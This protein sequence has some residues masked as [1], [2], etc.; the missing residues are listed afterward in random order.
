MDGA[1]EAAPEGLARAL[2]DFRAEAMGRM[3]EGIRQALMA[4]AE[5]LA[6]SGIAE[7]AVKVGDRAPDFALPDTAGRT[8]RLADLRAAGPVVVSFYR[9]GWC[10]FCSLEM[11]HLGR[12]REAIERA[13]ARIVAISPQTPEASGATDAKLHPGFPL[14]CDA[15]GEVAAAY[16]LRY[17]LEPELVAAYRA[18]GTDLPAAN[19]TG[20]WSL[21][22]P[23]T[24]VIGP[25]GT[26][27][28]AHVDTDYTTRMEPRA[29]LEALGAA[30]PG[31]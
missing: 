4:A 10:P 21:P 19:G 3:P 7:R 23:A 27:R 8:V 24:Y 14:L 31:T 22:V 6:A 15:G 30:G 9:G 26:V 17:A 28:A 1:S 12:A 13:G 16:G 11:A 20:D 29:V 2:A 18:M 25:D 5:R